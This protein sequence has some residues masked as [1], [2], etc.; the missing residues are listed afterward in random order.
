ML[1]NL[2]HDFRIQRDTNTE[3]SQ[4]KAS[5][6]IYPSYLLTFYVSF[7]KLTVLQKKKPNGLLSIKFYIHPNTF[8]C[9]WTKS[10][11]LYTKKPF[12]GYPELSLF[13]RNAWRDTM[14]TYLH[15]FWISK[16]RKIYSVK[17]SSSQTFTNT[18]DNIYFMLNWFKSSEKCIWSN[19]NNIS[20]SSF[21]RKNKR[22]FL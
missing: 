5:M 17:N 21:S 4:A 18:Y 19:P 20:F 12:C 14:I 15:V 10:G 9:N 3:S 8:F 1:V 22:F 13:G 11:K 6:M 2:T 16:K 7:Y